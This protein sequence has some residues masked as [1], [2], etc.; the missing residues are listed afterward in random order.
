MYVLNGT[1]T[2][3][4]QLKSVPDKYCTIALKPNADHERNTQNTVNDTQVKHHLKWLFAKTSPNDEDE[5]YPVTVSDISA[6]K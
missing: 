3:M 4:N 1:L 2:F 5:I 6:A